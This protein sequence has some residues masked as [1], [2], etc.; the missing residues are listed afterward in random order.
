MID[1]RV[2]RGDADIIGEVISDPMLE[3]AAVAIQRGRAEIDRNAV[4]QPVTLQTRYREGLVPGKIV[5]VLD[6][7]QGTVWR[8]KLREVNLAVEGINITASL[9]IEKV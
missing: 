8:G 1:I 3:T 5:E 2:I 9:R 7:L 6:A 4:M